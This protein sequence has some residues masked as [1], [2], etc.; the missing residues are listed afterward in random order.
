MILCTKKKPAVIIMFA[1]KK[2]NLFL[3]QRGLQHV[4]TTGAV[5][6]GQL[7]WQTGP[8]QPVP[9]NWECLPLSFAFEGVYMEGRAKAALA[10]AFLT[11]FSS[12][13]QQ[14]SH[15]VMIREL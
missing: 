9:V 3:K 1:P 11:L 15:T 8:V 5:R 6:H 14:W 4:F 2:K 10:T 13:G 7:E 12:C